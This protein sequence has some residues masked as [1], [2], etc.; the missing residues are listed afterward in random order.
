ER[1]HSGPTIGLSE[2]GIP[3]EFSRDLVTEVAGEKRCLA[4]GDL[5]LAN[6]QPTLHRNSIQA[7]RARPTEGMT[8]RL[9]PGV[10]TP[11]NADFDGDKM[12]MY[13]VMGAKQRIGAGRVCSVEINMLDFKDSKLNFKVSQDV[14]TGLHILSLLETKDI[15]QGVEDVEGRQRLLRMV[16]SGTK[17]DRNNLGQIMCCVRQ[18][19]VFGRRPEKLP[20]MKHDASPASTGFVRLSYLSGLLPHEMFYHSQMEREVVVRTG[21]STAETGYA[22]RMI[23]RLAEGLTVWEDKTVRDW[24]DTIVQFG[25][26]EKGESSMAQT[27]EVKLRFL[28]AVKRHERDAQAKLDVA[29]SLWLRRSG[30]YEEDENVRAARS[31]LRDIGKLRD[32]LERE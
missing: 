20:H 25:Y 17:G 31:R 8:I 12:S 14:M 23:S 6:R 3:R 2:A 24:D 7:L 9:N 29:L 15:H 1:Y 22:Q 30:E 32:R 10:I 13:S 5:I 4:D 26:G 28:G 19:L 16:S 21:I 11:F 18:Q 27:R